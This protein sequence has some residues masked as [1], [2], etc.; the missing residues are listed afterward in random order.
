[1]GVCMYARA[2]RVCSALG[3]Q[4]V[5]LDLLELELQM[6][7]RC[8]VGSGSLGGQ[9]VRLTAEP[10]ISCIRLLGSFRKGQLLDLL[11][12]LICGPKVS[13]GQHP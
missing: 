12:L 4:K 9:S 5:A 11:H 13:S 3:G 2:P 8:Q 6:V 10:F 1:M 7:V